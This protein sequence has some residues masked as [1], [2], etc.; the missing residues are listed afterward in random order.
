MNETYIPKLDDKTYDFPAPLK[1]VEGLLAWGGDLSAK[2]LIS[3]YKS[4]VFPWYS[5]REPILWWS[6]NPRAVIYPKDIHISKSLKK[7][8]KHYSVKV[9][10]D[11]SAVIGNCKSVR[12]K[13]GEATW[14]DKDMQ[15]AYINLHNLGY[16]HSVECYEDGELVGGLY[17]VCVGKIFCGE[18][19][20][21]L[22]KDASKTALVKLCNILAEYE[23]PI[24]DCQMPTS[25]L[26]SMGAVAMEKEEYLR[27]LHEAI[28][29]DNGIENW[30]NL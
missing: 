14:I 10:N 29:C 18:S 24:L 15:K 26:M 16:A 28:K 22:K 11:F 1:S 9:D 13:N 23:F 6:P 8:M 7:T 27:I 2:R 5:P 12:E 21:S 17:G 25:H 19:M 4:G 20:F 3:A 30:K